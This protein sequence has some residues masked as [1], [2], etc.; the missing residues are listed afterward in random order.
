MCYNY[1]KA[2]FERQR[3]YMKHAEIVFSL[4]FLLVH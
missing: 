2:Y 1:E 4:C 3:I